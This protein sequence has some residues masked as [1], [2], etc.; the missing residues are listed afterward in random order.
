MH[1]Q[2]HGEGEGEGERKGEDTARAVPSSEYV[3]ESGIIRL[4]EKNFG[5]WKE[6]YSFLDLRAEL[7]SLTDFAQKNPDKWF[8]AVQ[9]ALAKRNRG[10]KLAQER[11]GD[12][13]FK[14]MSGMQGVI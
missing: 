10:A 11:A 3:F 14:L 12:G 13:E 5:Q 7:L 8:F 4:S 1:V 9:G 2:A 6:A